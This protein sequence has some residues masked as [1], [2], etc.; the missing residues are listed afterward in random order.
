MGEDW[1]VGLGGFGCG[2]VWGCLGEWGCGVGEGGGVGL[3][4][5]GG[6]GR[7]CGAV[8]WERVVV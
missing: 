4:C 3:W 8:V 6:G 5:R 7:G 2:I 1:G